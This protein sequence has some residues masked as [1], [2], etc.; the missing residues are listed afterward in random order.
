MAIIPFLAMTA[1]EMRNISKIPSKIAWMACHFSPYGLGL[2]NL[3]Q[4]LPHGSLLML[5]DITPPHGHDPALITEQLTQCVEEFQCS[6]ILLDFQ[7]QNVPETVEIVRAIIEQVSCPVGVTEH[8]A[9]D[10]DCAVFL[11]HVPPHL[12]P[13]AYLRPW[14]K[15]EIWLEL[16]LDGTRIA[17]TESGCKFDP[18]DFPKPA[19]DC[20]HD[21]EL[22][23][24]YHTT[25]S[26]EQISFHLYRRS[27]DLLSLLSA[28]EAL[29]VEKAVGLYQELNEAFAGK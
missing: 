11:P 10:F 21:P 28:A 2:S 14:Q 17:V 24:H 15:R 8:Y 25:V 5:D 9:K 16:A 12:P 1:A 20:H 26:D 13:E 27:E 3:P 29:G 18:L 19:E 23:C 7:R 22:H 4:A 6:G